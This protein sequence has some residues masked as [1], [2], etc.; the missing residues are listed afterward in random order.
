ME[1]KLFK[2]IWR[3]SKREQIAILLLVALSMPFYFMSLD[4]PKMIV[5]QGILGK[6]FEGA[7]DT[8]PFLVIELPF[9]EALTGAPVTIFE[10]FSLAQ[11]GLLLSLTVTYIL[12]Y[13]INSGFKY[14]IN[15]GKGRLGERMLRRLRY[16]LT[17]R[18]LRFPIPQIR[19]VKQAEAA[20]MIKDEVEPLGG[21]IG[22]AFVTPAFLG[23]QAITA[24]VF[25]LVQNVWLGLVAAVIVT[26]QAAL[27]PKMRVPILLLGR[28][29]QLTARQ[30]AGRVAEVVDGAI[31]IH[32]HDTSNY[33]RRDLSNRLGRIFEIRYEIFQRKF[34]VKFVN[35]FL[36]QLTPFIFYGG[37][38]VLAIHGYLDVGALVA[39]IFAYKDLPGPI[40]ELID[41]DQQR[42]DVQ[43]KYEQVIEQFQPGQLL[44]PLVQGTEH[45]A[46]KPLRGQIVVSAVSLVDDTGSRLVQSVNFTADHSAHLAII[47]PPGSGKEHLALLLARLA[48]PTSGKIK[49][50]EV[51]LDKLPQTVTGRRIGYLGQDTYLFPKSVRE[52][53]LYVLSHGPRRGGKTAAGERAQHDAKAAESLRAGNPAWDIDDDWTDYEAAGATGR[54]DIDRR[55][56]EYISLVD[57]ADDVYRFGLSG[58]VDSESHPEIAEAIMRARA[59]LPKRLS[60]DKGEGLVARFDPEAYNRNAT[61]AENLLFGTPRKPAFMPDALVHNEI[62]RAALEETGLRLMTLDMGITIARTMVE[63][64][65][66]LPPGHPFFDQF[67][68]IDADDLPRFRTLVSKVDKQGRDSLDMQERRALRGLPFSYIEARHRLSLV[69]DDVEERA[70]ATR[71]IFAERLALRDP[72][73]VAF[74]DPETYNAAA[75]L[76]DNILFGRIVYGQAK[77]EEIVG[78]AMTEVL[79]ALG[80]RDVV[81]QA[82]LDFQVG[83]GGKRLSAAQRQK[84]GLARALLKR[85]D[86]LIV[87]DGLAVLDTGSQDRLLMRVLENRKGSGVIW[88]LQRPQ[89][90]E[91][92]DRVLVMQDGR[93]VEQGSYTDLVKEGSALNG[94]QA[95]E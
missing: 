95:A 34:F 25:I 48:M 10:G 21:F 57:L 40:K 47:G 55:I 70:V 22:D 80:L 5:N 82:G 50:G 58:T 89:S 61:L 49:I 71:K 52:N 60:Q 37:G 2:Y 84:L 6:G 88:V 20:T 19:K 81:I 69:N 45:D 93:I 41:W 72:N 59:E 28:Q 64:F 78:R 76:Q 36:A 94:I 43:I 15:T 23:G 32:A 44:D 27:V 39:V 90:C 17:D 42:Q 91:R 86:I 35:N 24:M 62:M 13:L 75:S 1:Q 92:F 30:L 66:D 38:G 26:V 12:L 33:E 79:D 46:G 53:M 54:E 31:E 29:R 7:A 63:L 85:P 77:A 74:Y 73:A 87:N 8:K 56:I 18:L 51:D 83:V 4:L 9:G 16:E 65:A 11:Q 3:Y 14:A 67:S 68:F